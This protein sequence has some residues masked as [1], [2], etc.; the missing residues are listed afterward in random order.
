MEIS[1]G[2]R[3]LSS[4]S[5][6]LLSIPNC[7]CNTDKSGI[8]QVI[9]SCVPTYGPYVRALS[10]NI[11]S[12]RRTRRPTYDASEQSSAF[13]FGRPGRS[14]AQSYNLSSRNPKSAGSRVY[15]SSVPTTGVVGSPSVRGKN[16]STES[17]LADQDGMGW[18]NSVEDGGVHGNWY[19]Q[20]GGGGGKKK[21][22]I[23]IATEVRVERGPRGEE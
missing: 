21:K 10:I 16:Y 20:E 5:L 22:G 1:L 4:S 13:V 3:L 18:R 6:P 19:G 11:S 12:Y 23:H 17:I 9:V 2:V 14:G 7:G 8:Q 15:D